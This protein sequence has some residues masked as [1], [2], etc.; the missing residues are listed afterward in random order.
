[1]L[2][3]VD[4]SGR[5]TEEV[6]PNGSL[7]NIAGIVNAARNVFGLMPHPEHAC[8]PLLGRADGVGFFRSVRATLSEGLPQRAASV[9]P[10]P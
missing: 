1:M 2:R 8:E 4:A 7:R 3:Y 10:G 5:A 6:N 9:P